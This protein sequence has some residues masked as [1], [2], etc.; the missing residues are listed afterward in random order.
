MK[1]STLRFP[2]SPSG[3]APLVRPRTALTRKVI[4][5]SLLGLSAALLAL[6]VQAQQAQQ[7][8]AGTVDSVPLPQ[9][10]TLVGTPAIYQGFEPC[11]MIDTRNPNGTFAGP[12]LVAGATRTFDLDVNGTGGLC[13]NTFPTNVKAMV[14]NVT[15]VNEDGPGFVTIYPG[16]GTQPLA[17]SINSSG[18]N[19]VIANEIVMPLAPDGTIKVYTSVGTHLVMDLVGIFTNDLAAGDNF[20]VTGNIGTGS[21]NGMIEAYNASTTTTAVGVRGVM[22]STAP[23]T[24]SA[25]VRGISN[26]TTANGIGVWGSQSGSGY[27]VYGTVATNGSGVFGSAATTGRGVFGQTATGVGVYGSATGGGFAGFFQGDVTILGTLSKS[28]GTFKID[29]P[30]D[31]ANKYLSHSFIE[32]PDMMNIYNGNVTTNAKGEA[33]VTM[34]E[35]FSALNKDFRYQLTPVGSFAQ[36]MVAKE[37][38]ENKFVIKTD[39]PNVKVSWQVTGIRHDAY[40]DAHR[41]AVEEEKTGIER[42]A[43]L[44]PELFGQPKEKGI[45]YA[46]HP[47]MHAEEQAART[48]DSST[49]HAGS[50]GSR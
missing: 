39:K 11:R 24:N 8:N 9:T 35:Y 12:K 47:E 4:G 30:A 26:S 2:L 18:P 44:H 41:T 1:K 37:I 13:V 50:S 28:A 33:V 27:G 3:E 20:F 46:R 10:H 6:T 29:H 36:A 34:P 31:P 49:E 22:L 42:G 5:F 32:S 19:T 48:A 45:E 21:G 40:A 16:N 14:V 17:S 25:G 7:P 15:I 43:Y 38:A 23:G